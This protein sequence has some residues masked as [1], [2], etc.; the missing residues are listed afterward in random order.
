MSFELRYLEK[1]TPA[2]ESLNMPFS[3]ENDEEK[4]MDEIK[5]KRKK[6][7]AKREKDRKKN[8]EE[9]KRE[10]LLATK[11]SGAERPHSAASLAK[12]SISKVT[13]P[14][15]STSGKFSRLS[16]PEAVVKTKKGSRKKKRPQTCAAVSSSLSAHSQSR[17]QDRNNTLPGL[18][19]S[20]VDSEYLLRLV[21]FRFV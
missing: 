5:K 21:A 13:S 6:K 20:D 12:H 1:K 18:I 8:E 7:K 3:S 14:V 17:D 15:P 16:S 11:L 10:I 19:V 9:G 4:A 2:P